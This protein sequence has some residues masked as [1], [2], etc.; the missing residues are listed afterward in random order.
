MSLALLAAIA[1]LAAL[2]SLNP[3][4]IVA[5][6][7]ILLGSRRR[8]VREA[9]GFVLGAFGSVLTVG[10]LVYVGADAAAASLEGALTWLRRAAFGLASLALLVAAV[11]ALRPRRRSA[12]GLPGWFNPFT[13]VA[14][15]V[16]MTGADL[17]TRSPTSSP[18][19]GS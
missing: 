11:R 13:A 1:G 18:S 8:P 5:V 17:P 14:A 9:L 3:A 12:V 6:A 15:G 10:V 16:V 7:L 19:S 2:D 4:T